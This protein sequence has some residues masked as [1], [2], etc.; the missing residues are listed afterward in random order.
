VC[1][2]ISEVI[3]RNQQSS[4]AKVFPTFSFKRK[5]IENQLLMQLVGKSFL[6]LKL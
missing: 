2:Q 1:R 5:F 6:V 3:L 4:R